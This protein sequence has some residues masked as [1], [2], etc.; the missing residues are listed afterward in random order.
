[1]ISRAELSEY[2]KLRGLTLA[3]AEKDYFQNLILFAIYRTHGNALVFKGGTALAKCYGS[4]RFSEDLDFTAISEFKVERIKKMLQRFALGFETK[5]KGFEKSIKIGFRIKGP[6]YTGSLMSLCRVI[7]DVSLREEVLLRPMVKTLGRFMEE[8]PEFD[9]YVMDE[10]EIL[11]EKI[12]AVMGRNKA[13]DA[14]DVWFLLKEGIKIDEKLVEK[15]LAYYGLKW[16]KKEFREM[17]ESKKKIWKSE[18]QPLVRE[19]PEFKE[20]LGLI[21]KKV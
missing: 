3:Q 10:R 7:I 11:A 13:R 19:L 8:I 20:I 1:M 4:R 9:V 2:A 18:M 12:R 6:L 17:L 5:E 14:Y 15:K 16:D 21:L